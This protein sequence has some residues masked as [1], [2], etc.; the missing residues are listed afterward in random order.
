MIGETFSLVS[1][2]GGLTRFIATAGFIS[3]P[4]LLS[5]VGG[6]GNI[7]ISTTRSTFFTLSTGFLTASSINLLDPLN[8]NS[9]NTLRTQSTLLYFNTLVIGGARVAQ[10]QLFTF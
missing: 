8:F 5:T 7:Y 4:N 6:L 2:T 9:T 3:S 1:T 10:E